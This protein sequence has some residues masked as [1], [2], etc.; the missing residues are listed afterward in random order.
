M[1]SKSEAAPHDKP[2]S[3]LSMPSFLDVIPEEW[4]ELTDIAFEKSPSQKTRQQVT[5]E[6]TSDT[7]TQHPTVAKKATHKFFP[8]DEEEEEEEEEAVPPTPPCTSTTPILKKGPRIG[9][10]GKRRFKFSGKCHFDLHSSETD[11]PPPV[12]KIAAAR[13]ISPEYQL[14]TRKD[15]EKQSSSQKM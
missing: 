2:S 15:T 6:T 3:E 7:G 4:P 14:P 11:V 8:P 1:V 12:K 13:S 5:A 10:G 9:K